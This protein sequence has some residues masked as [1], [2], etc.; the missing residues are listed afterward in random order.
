MCSDPSKCGP[1]APLDRWSRIINLINVTNP[2]DDL[3]LTIRDLNIDH[4][5]HNHML[6]AVKVSNF[7]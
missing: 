4:Y 1:A 3:M 7:F 5:A 2:M 6:E